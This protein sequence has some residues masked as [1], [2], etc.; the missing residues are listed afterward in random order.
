M[1]TVRDIWPTPRTRD[2][3]RFILVI[4]AY[5]CHPDAGQRAQAC[6]NDARELARSGNE[7]WIIT[8]TDNDP[9]CVSDESVNLKVLFW[10]LPPSMAVLERNAIG[11]WLHRKLW[12]W[13][14]NR[15]IADWQTALAIS[16]IH[17]HADDLES[18]CASD[19][20]AAR[21]AAIDA[22]ANTSTSRCA[23]T[24]PRTPP[25]ERGPVF[26]RRSIA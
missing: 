24:E 4:S 18:A 11:R 2:G 10:Q 23:L 25:R 12:H 15:A 16:V 8:A 17:R 3:R 1:G 6:W 19:A 22:N 21:K 9:A 14:V 5:E 26:S 20:S 7:V 13:H